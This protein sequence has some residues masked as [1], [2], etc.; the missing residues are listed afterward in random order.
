MGVSPA[1]TSPRDERAQART[2][3][4][5]AQDDLAAIIL[6]PWRGQASNV[7]GTQRKVLDQ[8]EEIGVREP[9][10]QDG[11]MIEV[12]KTKYWVKWGGKATAKYAHWCSNPSRIVLKLT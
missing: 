12:A 8:F 6:K 7:K 11:V 9:K 1:D 3:A 4:R 5:Q 2:E 10:L